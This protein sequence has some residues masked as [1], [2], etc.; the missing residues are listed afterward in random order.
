MGKYLAIRIT[1]FS[2]PE[3]AP[4]FLEEKYSVVFDYEAQGYLILKDCYGSGGFLLLEK[5]NGLG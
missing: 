2:L 4:G 5:D 3:E 1:P